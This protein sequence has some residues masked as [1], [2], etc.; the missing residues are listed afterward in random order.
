MLT[1]QERATCAHTGRKKERVGGHSEG[2][3]VKGEGVC[4]DTETTYFTDTD[5]TIVNLMERGRMLKGV[6]I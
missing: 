4:V 6:P 5:K 3:T 2:G 1:D